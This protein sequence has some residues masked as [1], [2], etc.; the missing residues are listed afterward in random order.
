VTSLYE[1]LGEDAAIAKVV[2]DFYERILADERLAPFFDGTDMPAL[3]RHQV[4]FLSAAT[5]GPKPYTGPDLAAAHAGRGI[6]D[7]HFDRVVGHLVAAL[8][9]VGVAPDVVDE[10]VTALAPLRGTIVGAAG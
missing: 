3:R 6:E 9:S 4:A 8:T 7:E 2:D 1:K 5:G 10:A